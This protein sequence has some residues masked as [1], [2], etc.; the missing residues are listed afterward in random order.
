MKLKVAIC[1]DEKDQCD[2]IKELLLYYELEHEIDFDITEFY[3]GK[4]LLEKYRK[5]GTF[6]IL[7]LDVGLP[8]I[9]GLEIARQIRQIPDKYVK[10]IFISNYSQYMQESFNVQAFQYFQKPVKYME[11]ESQLNRI[12]EEVTRGGTEKILIGQ[13]GEEELVTISEIY[14]IQTLKERKNY[15]KFH[16]KNHNVIMRGILSNWQNNLQEH[17]F[18]CSCRG[19]VVN[20]NHVRYF[21]DGMMEMDNGIKVPFSRRKE[22]EFRSKFSNTIIKLN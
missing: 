11:F 14:Y 10:I 2:K 12:L 22:R 5:L 17:G 13:S 8:E 1:D 16:L 6:D 7:L 20:L 3:N 4:S 9:D 15:L 19:I 18:I 21:R